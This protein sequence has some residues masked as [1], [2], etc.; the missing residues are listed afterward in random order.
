MPDCLL[1]LAIALLPAGGD[2]AGAA[3]AESFCVPRSRS[4][5]RAPFAGR[6]NVFAA[7]SSRGLD[8]HMAVAAD[9]LS[10]GPMTGA[11]PAV[12]SR[13]GLQ[14]GLSQ[15]VANG[16]GGF[17]AMADFGDEGVPR[18]SPSLSACSC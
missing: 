9:L 15:V 18:R 10:D 8:G 2:I 14:L 6:G 7:R 16:P 4:G 5:S 11:G 13:L 1:V 3:I 17:A 12:A